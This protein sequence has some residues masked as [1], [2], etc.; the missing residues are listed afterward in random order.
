[1]DSIDNLTLLIA[2]IAIFVYQRE[3]PTRTTGEIIYG[4]FL[5]VLASF[6]F[7]FAIWGAIW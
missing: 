3:I 6:M 7:I 5:F 2:G 4:T 1:M